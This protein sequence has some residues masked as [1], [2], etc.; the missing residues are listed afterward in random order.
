MRNLR[1]VLLLLAGGLC[2]G[3]GGCSHTRAADGPD[4]A[5]VIQ[6][7]HTYSQGKSATG[8]SVPGQSLVPSKNSAV[9]GDQ[10]ATY[11][12]QVKAELV[13]R[14]F[15]QLEKMARDAR[16]SK[17]RF[18]GG[19]WVLYSL[20]DGLDEPA[21]SS[22]ATDADWNYHIALLK[23]W[24]TASPESPTPRIALAATYVKFADKARGSG[25]ANTVSEQGWKLDAERN[26]L[27]LRTLVD[28]A[29][30]KEKCPFWFE[31]MQQIALGGGWT[32]QEAKDLFQQAVA[33]EPDYYHYYREYAYY[34]L[35]KWYGEPGEAEAFA[36]QVSSSVSGP[37]G[38]F[39][40][41]EIASLLT[42]QC[43][44][45][46]TDMENLSWPKIKEGYAA[47]GQLYGSSNLKRNRYA[48]MAV[49]AGDKAAAREAFS[50]IGDD[51]THEVWHNDR[52]YENA[53]SW[54]MNR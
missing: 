46:D 49:E 50:E 54:A 20:Y 4:H 42:C 2:F 27:A 17:S 28:A 16:L 10:E 7:V 22:Q 35:P 25:Y 31:V 1:G 19:V 26:Q 47:M 29:N 18:A 53:K 37:K 8:L 48:H 30:L 38:K 40:Y 41:F 6:A 43:D 15:A 32:K 5:A 11:E 44:S 52:T 34:L 45:T 23:E 33:F 9:L 14:H 24:I 21:T 51:W 12:N 36:E 3:F 39:L 13:D